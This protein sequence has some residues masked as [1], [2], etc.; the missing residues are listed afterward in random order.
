MHLSR[1]KYIFNE[2]FLYFWFM[3]DTIDL[4]SFLQR[5]NMTQAELSK[6]LDTTP[7]NVNPKAIPWEFRGNT[8]VLPTPYPLHIISLHYISY[9]FIPLQSYERGAYTRIRRIGFLLLNQGG[10]GTFT[11]LF[12]CVFVRKL[13]FLGAFMHGIVTFGH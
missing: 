13:P 6:A 3:S 8:A 5:V 4:L 11:A 9:H 1:G 10:G 12:W 7:G 2:F